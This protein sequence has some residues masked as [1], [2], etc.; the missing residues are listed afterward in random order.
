VARRVRPRY[1][2][3]MRPL[4]GVA[5]IVVVLGACGPKKGP[6]GAGG[7][8]GGGGGDGDGAGTGGGDGDGAGT[9]SAVAPLTRAECEQVFDHYL[10][11]GMEEQRKNKPAELV[12]TE[13][14]LADIR[15]KLLA[16]EMDGCLTWPRPVWACAMAAT[17][18]TGFYACAEGP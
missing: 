13:A 6:D 1:E 16:E 5:A 8:G 11:V 9:A 10:A 2:R 18:V 4:F 12:P 17:T 14:Q 15:T 7:G 3:E